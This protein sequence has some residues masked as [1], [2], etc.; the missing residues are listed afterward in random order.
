MK[1]LALALLVCC[2]AANAADCPALDRL[3]LH[4]T[5]SQ[6][7]DEMVDALNTC[8]PDPN[9]YANMGQTTVPDPS[10]YETWQIINSP[11]PYPGPSYED[12]QLNRRLDTLNDNLDSLRWT[13]LLES[14]H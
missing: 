14:G 5:P 7:V 13:I 9:A 4:G 2:A 3:V 1:Y 12:Q 6:M 8:P 11:L 10:F